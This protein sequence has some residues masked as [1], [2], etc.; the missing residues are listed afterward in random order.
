MLQPARRKGL[1]VFNTLDFKNGFALLMLQYTTTGTV[2]H[3][4]LQEGIKILNFPEIMII[5]SFLFF[6]LT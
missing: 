5:S 2:R 1:D 4:Q 6:T 3:V